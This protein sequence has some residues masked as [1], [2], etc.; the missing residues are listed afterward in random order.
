MS[1]GD[2]YGKEEKIRICYYP[3]LCPQIKILYLTKLKWKF[4]VNLAWEKNEE[5][6][7]FHEIICSSLRTK[8]K[9]LENRGV[10]YA[11]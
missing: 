2:R 7:R 1:S 11:I 5:I 8:K 3:R 6:Y 9:H 10:Q 4:N